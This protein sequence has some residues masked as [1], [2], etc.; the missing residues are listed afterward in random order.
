VRDFRA[1]F[2]GKKEE[3]IL[4]RSKKFLPT[5]Q[6]PAF[7]PPLPVHVGPTKARNTRTRNPIAEAADFPF[8]SLHDAANWFCW[9]AEA[10]PD[11]PSNSS[12]PGNLT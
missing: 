4:T 1:S 10:K 11:L 3:L 5:R 2:G 8:P 7:P 9:V 12:R 6:S